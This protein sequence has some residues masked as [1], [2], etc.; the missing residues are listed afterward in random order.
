MKNML[1][2][3]EAKIIKE[4]DSGRAR[5]LSRSFFLTKKIAVWMLVAAFLILAG[6]SLAVLTLLIRYGDWDI[7]RF[8][9]SSPAAFFF[10]AFPY[11]WL[12]GVIGFLVAALFRTR[13]ADG[14]YSR[15]FV[16]HGLVGI[17]LIIVF[18]GVF[19]FSGIGQKTETF[20]AGSEIYRKANYLRSSWDNPEKGLLAGV[21]ENGIE[22]SVGSEEGASNLVLRDFNNQTWR[23][24]LPEEDFFGRHLFLVGEKVKI[25]GRLADAGNNSVFL[26][27]EARPWKCGCQ[28]CAHQAGSCQQCESG[29]CPVSGVCHGSER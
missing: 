2:N 17:S 24:V 19:Y 26:V 20:L 23:L 25:I 28:K 21:I 11:A 9:D 15:P 1:D 7:Y 4:I 6:L 22:E 3:L 13:R 12:L 27:S 14:V 16:Y 8:L 18:A 10:R 29:A 5:P